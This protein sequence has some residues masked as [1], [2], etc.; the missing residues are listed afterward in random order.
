MAIK[1]NELYTY[2]SMGEPQKHA[3]WNKL[4][5]KGHKLYDSVYKSCPKKAGREKVD[6]WLPTTARGG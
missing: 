4:H 1:R 6:I 5:T 3:E 2:H